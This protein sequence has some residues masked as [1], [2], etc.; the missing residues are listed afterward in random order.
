V[1]TLFNENKVRFARADNYDLQ[2]PSEQKPIKHFREKEL[3]A[4]P[5]TPQFLGV[6]PIISGT[7]KATD[8][9]F[10]R[11]IDRVFVNNSPLKTSE[12]VAI[13]VVRES[14]TFSRHPYIGRIARLSLR[15]HGFLVSRC[16]HCSAMGRI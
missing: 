3:W 13:S 12:T 11:Y 7:G 15:Q 5:G 4:Y 16:T 6:P 8:F 2:G 10:G 14:C 1:R 9:K